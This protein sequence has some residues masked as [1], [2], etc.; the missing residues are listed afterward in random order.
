MTLPLPPSYEWGK[1]VGRVIHAIAD[2]AADADRDPEAR[3][4]VGT[5]TF[6]PLTTLRTADGAFISHGPEVVSL[7]S[8]GYLVDAEGEQGVWLVTGSYRVQFTLDA[9]ARV[10][11]FDVTVSTDHTGVGPVGLA[12][13]APEVP[14]GGTTG[15]V[16]IAGAPVEGAVVAFSDGAARWESAAAGV[17]D[18]GELTG[19][20]DDDH[21]QYALADG[22]RGAFA[23]TSH[24]HTIPD[25]TGLQDALDAAGASGGVT[26]HGALTGLGGDDHTQYALADG[27]RGDFATTA[28]GALAETAVQPGDL[29]R[30]ATTGAY[31]DLTGK[32]TIP[33]AASAITVTLTAAAWSGDEQAVTAAGVTATNIILVGPSPA[34]LDDWA[35]A[36]VRATVQSADS[37]TFAAITTPAVDLSAQVVIL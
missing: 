35:A 37:L 11:P 34:S 26:D 14:D 22:S 3:A 31:A 12:E 4:A 5:V 9:G 16:A 19:L 24:T 1:V 30:V 7:D 33:A 23:A 36:G 15:T 25:V 20:S 10:S 28:Q 32:P 18:H 13:A 8:S 6:T 27:T 29:A 2:T 21:A 17:T